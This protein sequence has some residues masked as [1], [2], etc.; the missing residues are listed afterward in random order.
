MR[1]KEIISE[2]HH[3]ILVTMPIG[4]WKVQIDSHAYATLPARNIPLE[5]F[6]NMIS[7][8]C[9]LPDVLPTIPVGKGAY[10]QDTN[11]AISIYVTRVS[12][13]VIRVETVLDRTMKPKQP[14]FRRAVPAPD[15]TNIKPVDYGSLKADVKARGRDAVSQ[16]IEKNLQPI[17]P[18]NRAERRKFSK[19]MRRLK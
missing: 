8:M 12:N 6:T 15:M 3:S 10:F 5:N 4:P 2:A 17:M 16:D 11:T 7:Y 9:F 19:L 14:L 18:V 1:L 13:N